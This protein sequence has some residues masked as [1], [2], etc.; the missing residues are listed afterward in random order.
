MCVGE[1]FI[2]L[3]YDPRHGF[4]LTTHK[5]RRREERSEEKSC[6][7][8]KSTTKLYKERG[9][10]LEIRYLGQFEKEKKKKKRVHTQTIFSAYSL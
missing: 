9:V 5:K 10:C 7:R 2:K 3:C 6:I 1:L 8:F 4:Y